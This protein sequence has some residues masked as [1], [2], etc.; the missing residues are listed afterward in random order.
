MKII[1]KIEEYE[2]EE[3]EKDD[4]S[5]LNDYNRYDECTLSASDQE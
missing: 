5:Y 1:E 2:V 3:Q 4:D